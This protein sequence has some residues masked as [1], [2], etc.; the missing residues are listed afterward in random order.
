MYNDDSNSVTRI[1]HD[2]SGIVK[3]GTVMA[4]GRLD[5]ISSSHEILMRLFDATDRGAKG[6]S[7]PR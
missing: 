6:V 7:G 5:S 2:K 1:C 3:S 4:D